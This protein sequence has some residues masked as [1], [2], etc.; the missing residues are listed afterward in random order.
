MRWATLRLKI[1]DNWMTQLLHD[2]RDVNIRVFGCMPYESRGGRGLMRL[3]SSGKLDAIL[4]GIRKREDVIRTSFSRISERAAFGEVVIKKCAAC[5]A[6][7]RSGCFMFSSKSRP[8]GWLEWAV[9]AESNGTAYDLI[10]LLKRYGC[11]VQLSRISA[12]SGSIGLTQ[13]Q[14]DIMRFAYSS[15]YYEY[16]RRIKLRELSQIFDISPSTMSEI[17]RAGQRRVFSEYFGF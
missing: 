1:P 12:S 14:E 2:R 11:E 9:A 7:K 15:G 3:S 10:D 16:P 6:L 5:M 8:D 13:R 4:D 17:L